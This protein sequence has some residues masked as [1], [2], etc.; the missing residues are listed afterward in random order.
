MARLEKRW[1]MS[2]GMQLAV[3]IACGLMVSA[4]LLAQGF[5]LK[6]GEWSM[7]MT[8]QGGMPMDG[9]PPAMRAQLEAEFK[10]PQVFTTCV[11]PED[12]K[13]LNLGKKDD[14]DEEDCKVVSS[15]ISGTAADITRT[16]MGDEP[17]TETSHFEAP[18]PQTM[19]GTV[20]KKTAKGTMTINLSGKFVGAKCTD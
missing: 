1:T 13:N 17:S 6:T 5:G 20:V 4:T 2:R 19:T 11:T 9:I 15:K 8:V 10:K 7:T 12:L 3:A 18:T 16:C 14:S